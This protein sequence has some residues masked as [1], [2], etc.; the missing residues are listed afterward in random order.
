MGPPG[1]GQGAPRS[2]H[3]FASARAAQAHATS[4][5]CAPGSHPAHPRSSRGAATPHAPAAVSPRG[6]RRSGLAS[7]R[8]ASFPGCRRSAG[9]RRDLSA[10]HRGPWH[11]GVSGF[12]T[13]DLHLPTLDLPMV[14][15][16]RFSPPP[17]S[18]ALLC[19]PESEKTFLTRLL[20]QSA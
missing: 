15:S 18:A 20:P 14:D 3:L 19:I 12:L 6:R 7:G 11:P 4:V 2:A 16:A 1:A 8:R 9:L 13:F 5:A 17:C 10:G